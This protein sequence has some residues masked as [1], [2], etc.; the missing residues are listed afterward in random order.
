MKS[1][2]I[3]ITCF[4]W[5]ISSNK[6]ITTFIQVIDEVLVNCEAIS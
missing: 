2:K 1:K 5:K 6:A 3:Q 4:N